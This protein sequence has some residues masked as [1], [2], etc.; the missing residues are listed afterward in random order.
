MSKGGK[1]PGAGRPKTPEKFKRKKLNDFR[2]M[3]YV[4]EWIKRQPESGGRLIEDALFDKYEKRGLKRLKSPNQALK[5][6]GKKTP[7]P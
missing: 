3:V 5:A 4:I 1:Q 7:A 2:A 6:T